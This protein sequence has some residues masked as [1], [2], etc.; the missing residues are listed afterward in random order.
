MATPWAA[1]LPYSDITL[2]FPEKT[3]NT[4]PLTCEITQFKAHGL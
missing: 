1:F 2:A 3:P 4:Q